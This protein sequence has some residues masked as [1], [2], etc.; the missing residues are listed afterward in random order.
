MNSFL[1]ILIL[2]VAGLSLPALAPLSAQTAPVPAPQELQAQAQ[3]MVDAL[4][5]RVDM[6]T[7]VRQGG[8]TP[9]AALGRLKAHA[10]PSGLKVERDASFA[11][12]ALDVG[13]RLLAADRAGEAEK[14]FREAEKA[15]DKVIQKTPDSAARDKAQFLGARAHIRG[16]FLAKIAEARADLEAA[17]RLQPDDPHLQQSLD[18]LA[19]KNAEQ[20]KDKKPRG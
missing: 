15:L 17:L 18:V 11:Y 1:R 10:G 16:H 12:A 2:I 4:K 5:L 14:F 6:A 13:Q 19:S 8:E 3:T 20:F 9:E 7:A